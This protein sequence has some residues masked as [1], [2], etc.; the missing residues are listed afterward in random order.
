MLRPLTPS[1]LDALTELRAWAADDEQQ[2]E[3]SWRLTSGGEFEFITRGETC[4]YGLTARPLRISDSHRNAD[5]LI[6]TLPTSLSSIGRRK[7]ALLP[8]EWVIPS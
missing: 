2:G 1:V 7:M 6:N 4:W 5:A 8:H 3:T